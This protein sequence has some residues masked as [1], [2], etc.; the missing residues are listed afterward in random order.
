MN[1]PSVT[2]EMA[3]AIR[4]AADGAPRLSGAF[5]QMPGALQEAELAVSKLSSVVQETATMFEGASK[6]ATQS[7]ERTAESGAEYV[8]RMGSSFTKLASFI[9][10]QT[11]EQG[12]KA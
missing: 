7:L 5:S 10:D 9:I 3:E 11:N 6:R 2:R 8:D 1:R 12:G 4:G